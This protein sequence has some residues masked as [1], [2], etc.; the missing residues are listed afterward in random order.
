MCRFKEQGNSW[1]YTCNS[2]IRKAT[3]AVKRENLCNFYIIWKRHMAPSACG[4]RSRPIAAA[5]D[6]VTGPA[7]QFLHCQL[8]TGVWKHQ[9]VFRGSLDL[10]RILDQKRFESHGEALINSTDVNAL[11]P[12]I[13]LER[14]MTALSWIVDHH[15]SFSQTL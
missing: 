14:G 3:N 2:I 4:I 6:Y 1:L 11:Y 12:S 15:T 7:S 10:I 8:Q 9:H 13:N 5:I